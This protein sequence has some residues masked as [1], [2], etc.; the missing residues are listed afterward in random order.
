MKPKLISLEGNR[1]KGIFE[2]EER[3]VFTYGPVKTPRGRHIGRSGFVFY[4]GKCLVTNEETGLEK[5]FLIYPPGDKESD[6]VIMEGDVQD[7]IPDYKK[8]VDMVLEKMFKKAKSSKSI[9]PE[10]KTVHLTTK[11]L[12]QLIEEA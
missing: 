8:A 12:C 3:T 10:I 11:D 4:H 2:I 7:A 6:L 5:R 1:Y 9:I